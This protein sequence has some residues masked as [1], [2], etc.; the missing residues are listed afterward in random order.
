MATPDFETRVRAVHTSL[1][2]GTLRLLEQAHGVR[3]VCSS[4]HT[5]TEHNSGTFTLVVS[6]AA[7]PIAAGASTP[8]DTWRRDLAIAAGVPVARITGVIATRFR[9]RGPLRTIEVIGYKSSNPENKVRLRELKTGERDRLMR[10][11]IPFLLQFL[12]AAV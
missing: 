6:E 10:C 5:D 7:S 8:V 9:P 12:A 3:V 1:V 11:S 2:G 4:P